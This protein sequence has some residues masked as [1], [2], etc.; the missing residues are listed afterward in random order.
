MDSSRKPKR[1]NPRE[2][3]NPLSQLFFLWI[4]PLFWKGS[5]TGLNT[6]DLTQCLKKDGSE[7]LGDE[8]E[9]YNC[10]SPMFHTNK[11]IS[12][13]QFFHSQT[14]NGTEKWSVLQDVNVNRVCEMQCFECSC[15]ISFLTALNALH[16]Y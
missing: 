11:M 6:D 16:S 5:R 12:S 13:C 4:I 7:M 8:L 1:E 3:A 14:E 9:R 2:G 10:H 15:H